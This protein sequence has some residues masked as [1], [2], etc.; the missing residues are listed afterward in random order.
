MVTQKPQCIV[1][2]TKIVRRYVDQTGRGFG[3]GVFKY[4]NEL[5]S[6]SA[7]P[8]NYLEID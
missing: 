3:I 8:I 6:Q 2:D 4:P 7:R 5:A 1:I